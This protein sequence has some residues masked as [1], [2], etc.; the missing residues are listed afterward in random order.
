MEYDFCS[1]PTSNNKNG[2]YCVVEVEFRAVQK[3]L[4]LTKFKTSR[5]RLKDLDKTYDGT[6]SLEYR[7]S[8]EDS[9]WEACE[10]CWDWSGCCFVHFKWSQK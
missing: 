7:D 2:C 4:Q 6:G 3:G 1:R 10:E 5:S 9:R 8:V